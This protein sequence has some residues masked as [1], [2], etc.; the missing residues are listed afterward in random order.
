MLLLLRAKAFPSYVLLLFHYKPHRTPRD[1][2]LEDLDA[3]V[4]VGRGERQQGLG[5]KA[6]GRRKIC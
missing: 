2:G 5:R 6:G 1:E 3:K 4:R